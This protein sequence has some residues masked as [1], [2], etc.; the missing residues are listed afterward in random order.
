MTSSRFITADVISTIDTSSHM[1]IYTDVG[2]LINIPV[3]LVVVSCC[4]LDRDCSR[5]SGL[6]SDRRGDIECGG[7]G[8]GWSCWESCKRLRGD[9]N[10]RWS[11]VMDRIIGLKSRLI[12]DRS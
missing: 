7:A 5:I 9:I 6:E 11:R 10:W 2:T 8:I 3:P 4:N 12:Q 1:D